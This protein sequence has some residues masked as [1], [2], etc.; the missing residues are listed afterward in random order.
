L[1]LLLSPA[2]LT[3]QDY[4][5]KA[6]APAPQKER[7]L[8]VGSSYWQLD[9]KSV[10]KQFWKKSSAENS[11]I[12]LINEC[13]ENEVFVLEPVELFSSGLAQKYNRLKN[14]RGHSLQRPEVKVRLSMSPHGISAWLRLPGANDFFI[15]PVRQTKGLHFGYLKNNQGYANAWQCKTL[16]PHTKKENKTAQKA[17]FLTPELR[18]FRIAIATTAEYTAFWGDDDDSN[19]TNQEDALAAVVSSLNRVNEIYEQE[20]QIHLELVTDTTLVYTDV[21]NDP[22]TNELNTE[23]QETLDAQIG[24]DAYDVGHL[25]GYGEPNGDAGCLGCVC[26]SGKKGSAYSSH[27]FE[28]PFGSEY[29]NDYFDLDYFGHELGHQFGAYHTFAFQIE[30]FGF[31][32]EPGSGTT[33]MGYAGIAGQD[34]VQRHGDPYFHYFSLQNI[35]QYVVQLACGASTPIANAIPQTNAG[36]DQIIPTGTAYALK[37]ENATAKEGVTYAWEQLDSGKVTHENF[38]PQNVVGPQNRSVSPQSHPQRTIPNMDRILAGKLTQTNP[39]VNQDWETVSEVGRQ[40]RWGLTVRETQNEQTLLAHDEMQIQVVENTGPFQ[41]LSQNER[42]IIWEAGT[43]KQLVWDVGGTYE[44]PIDTKTVS[45]FLSTDGGKEYPYVLL[46]NTPNDGVADIIVPDSLDIAKARIK[47]KADNSIY[48]AINDAFLAVASRDFVLS[49]DSFAQ[50]TC[51]TAEVVYDFEIKRFSDYDKDISLVINNLPE[52]LTARFSKSVY[53]PSDSRGRV[54]IGGIANVAPNDFTFD[55][56]AQSGLIT[57]DFQFDLAVR[58]ATLEAPELLLPNNGD[59]PINLKPNFEWTASINADNYRFQIAREANFQEVIK[60]VE[61]FSNH[62]NG[63]TLEENQTYY[64]RVKAE[65]NCGAGVYAPASIIKTS[66]LSCVALKVSDLPQPIDDAVNDAPK[67]TVFSFPVGYDLPIQDINVKVDIKHDWVEDLTLTLVAPNG[68]SILLS[69]QLGGSNANYEQ[70]V[71]DSEVT[72]S[73]FNAEAPFSGTFAP[74][75]S[76]ESLYGTSAF[77]E[78]TLEVTDAYSED[79][80]VLN[81]FEI[82]FCLLGVTLPNSDGDALVDEKDNCPEIT[83]QDQSDVD[84]NGIGDACDIFSAKNITLSKNNVSCI[85]KF[86]GRISLSAL[87][88]FDYLAKIIGPNNVDRLIR[89]SGEEQGVL[90]GLG[91]GTYEVCVTSDAF[92]SFEYCFDV[93]I[94]APDPFEVQ[95]IVKQET[96]LVALTLKGSTSYEIDWNGKRY[97]TTADSMAL[98]LT[99]KWNRLVVKTPLACQGVFET[100]IAN[101]SELVLFPNPVQT[102]ARVLLP[103]HTQAKEI[104][105][106]DVGGTLLWQTSLQERQGPEVNLPVAHLPAGLYL[107][108]VAYPGYETQLKLIKE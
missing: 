34:N 22:F 97:S 43:K 44:L 49:F 40:L 56:L 101:E 21:M 20:L 33:I 83:N 68:S 108:S 42:N 78:W 6:A 46:E 8:R 28:D 50:E 93:Q 57:Y 26:V 59:T 84:G 55:V 82:E 29:R 98:P 45:V 95:A 87:A 105:L 58:S 4:W 66:P 10:E 2:L 52:G 88:Q 102:V 81:Q 72:P 23:L 35:Q 53:R 25:F 75:Q 76:L 100:W 60:E 86:N 3:A 32:A 39:Q 96:Q 7:R 1:F 38:G 12:T 11:E 27:S 13:G 37:A 104:R 79:K 106:F 18:T 67:T 71:F 99:Q 69:Q 65:N 15:Q 54:T 31:N 61:V 14:Y 47:I 80:G 62:Y 103:Q 36:A 16:L 107:I 90:S 73:I 89:F 94:K 92:A 63:I 24:T 85:G 41:V 5:A 77:G 64:W 30:G 9:Q 74:I 19:G 17:T 70:T 91:A 51:D 48:F